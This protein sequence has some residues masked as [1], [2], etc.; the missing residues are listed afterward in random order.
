MKVF[1]KAKLALKKYVPN[2]IYSFQE[3][4]RPIKGYD[5][6]EV[7]NKGRIR[8]YRK[9]GPG[10]TKHKTPHIIR[11][12]TTGR[13]QNYLSFSASNSKGPKRLLVHRCVAEA[14]IPNP[15][16]KPEV[17]HKDKN[18]SN[19]NLTNLEWVTSSENKIHARGGRH[20]VP[21]VCKDRN[22]F[23]VH[24]VRDGIRTSKNFKSFADAKGF[25]EN[26]Y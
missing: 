4:W 10:K 3:V 14:F 16:N 19:N 12:S 5:G 7:S 18:G 23:R 26:I 15:K 17:N 24:Y 2:S 20:R 9:R 6:Y 25:A 11:L 1:E 13:D 8:S 21:N 22:S